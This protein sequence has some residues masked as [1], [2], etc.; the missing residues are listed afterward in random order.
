MSSR[1]VPYDPMILRWTYC[2][3]RRDYNSR[4]IKQFYNFQT[5][6]HTNC[7]T[8]MAI[9]NG[10]IFTIL[11]VT[12]PPL[13]GGLPSPLGESPSGPYSIS[14]FCEPCTRISGRAWA[15][16]SSSKQHNRALSGRPQAPSSYI[17]SLISARG[18]SA[19]SQPGQT[20]RDVTTR[21]NYST[22]ALCIL[23]THTPPILL[24]PAGLLTSHVLGL[25]HSSPKI[26]PYPKT[27]PIPS[28]YKKR[29]DE[30]KKENRRIQ[31][32]NTKGKI[33]PYPPVPPQTLLSLFAI[34]LTLSLLAS[35][36]PRGLAIS[37]RKESI[38]RDLYVSDD[39]LSLSLIIDSS[40]FSVGEGDNSD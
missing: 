18:P 20:W 3:Q 8:P 36:V 38:P 32:R 10:I 13:R 7:A 11:N 29:E 15:V 27:L 31:K 23:C 16:S 17:D 26:S 33:L 30:N 12:I 1:L 40:L 28:L 9:S 21:H 34:S 4:Y 37:P 14:Q 35:P 39:L 25:S 6:H 2:I 19:A 22:R 24:P 5:K